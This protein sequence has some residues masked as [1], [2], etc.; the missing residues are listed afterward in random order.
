M[1]CYILYLV[2]LLQR[3]AMNYNWKLY[4]GCKGDGDKLSEYDDKDD[5][6]PNNEYISEYNRVED[7]MFSLS[8]GLLFQLFEAIFD[9]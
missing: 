8:L 5:H 6:R 1:M 7:P 4:E 3:G 9:Y 2:A